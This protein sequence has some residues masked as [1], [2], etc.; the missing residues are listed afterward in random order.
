MQLLSRRQRTS[1]IG[2]H[3]TGTARLGQAHGCPKFGAGDA[4]QLKAPHGCIPKPCGSA[5]RTQSPRLT[6][7]LT[8]RA[9]HKHAAANR[10]PRR[11]QRCLGQ[12]LT[13]SLE[14]V[15][16]GD[17]PAQHE[18]R[19]Y[20][21]SARQYGRSTTP[22]VLVPGTHAHLRQ[23][24]REISG[25]LGRHHSSLGS[26]TAC[27]T[28][29]IGVG[30]ESAFQPMHT[31]AARF[32]RILLRTSAH[33]CAHHAGYLSR[34]RHGRSWPLQRGHH[35]GRPKRTLCR[36]EPPRQS[37]SRVEQGTN[38][39]QAQARWVLVCAAVSR[40]TCTVRVARLKSACG[41]LLIYLLLT[42]GRR[43]GVSSSIQFLRLTSPRQSNG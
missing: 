13:Q 33:R 15:T 34:R 14:H 5:L 35:D 9:C 2:S 19:A 6:G 24:A 30:S 39:D 43:P 42:P 18:H 3:R 40:G 31:H 37:S 7:A 28:S 41:W 8:G 1:Q 11:V 26:A 10:P 23:V 21:G 32:L 25:R 36:S 17:R 12:H 38:A 20:G 27:S 4:Q 16:M 22:L 29:P